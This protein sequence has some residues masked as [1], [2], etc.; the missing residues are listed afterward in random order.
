MNLFFNLAMV[1]LCHNF[2]ASGFRWSWKRLLKLFE[3][4]RISSFMFIQFG[5]TLGH[6][7]KFRYQKS[8][9][10]LVISKYLAWFW[11]LML[12]KKINLQSL[13]SFA[14]DLLYLIYPNET[15]HGRWLHT[16][17]FIRDL[18]T[19]WR[20]SKLYIILI[21]GCDVKSGRFIVA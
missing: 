19:E 9:S 4:V 21:Y 16:K 5:H 3:C 8:S 14:S 12:N 2:V 18:Q 1:V 10:E 6:F 11:R 15:F 17:C 7:E 20:L 13:Y